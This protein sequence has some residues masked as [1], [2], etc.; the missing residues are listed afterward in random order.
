[1][2]R[3]HVLTAAIVVAAGG[4]AG[5]ANAARFY[6]AAGDSLYSGS[7]GGGAISSG[8][9]AGIGSGRSPAIAF[10]SK[11]RL[12]AAVN[13]GGSSTLH[14][15]SGYEDLNAFAPSMGGTIGTFL[16]ETNSFDFR[17]VG[18][19]EVLIGT[20]NDPG[21]P[22][23]YESDDSTYSSFSDVGAT[24]FGSGSSYPS[25]GYDR[26]SG[27]YYAV[28]AGAADNNRRIVTI[29]TGTG[30]A[31][32][33][34]LS[35]VFDGVD[36]QGDAGYGLIRLAGGEYIESLSTYFISFY[37]VALD[38]AVIGTLD[39]TTGDFDELRAF[40]V[41]GDPGTMGLAVVI[42]TPLAG[43]MGGAGLMLVGARRRRQG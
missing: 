34:G 19:S 12:F 4:L 17:G 30:A 31:T 28:T 13:S 15:L 39:L 26:G 40:S 25:S 22:M 6:L 43:V 9:I 10:D 38:Q 23:Y 5:N 42:P 11:G 24:G 27:V 3:T 16:S 37:S 7:T 33:T 18:S 32:W 2:K 21:S 36:D 35:M 41:G 14:M 29:A 8:V 20:R 1:M